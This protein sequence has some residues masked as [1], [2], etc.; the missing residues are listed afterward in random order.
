MK[1]ANR[2]SSRCDSL[3]G[4][5]G[6][7][8]LLAESGPGRCHATRGEPAG[9]LGSTHETAALPEIARLAHARLHATRI[10]MRGIRHSFTGV[11]WIN[12]GSSPAQNQLASEQAEFYNELSQNYS[13]VFPEQQAVLSA[14]TSEFAPI[15]AAGPNQTGFSPQEETSLRTTASDTT[16][17]AA[18]Q[19]DVALGGKEATMGDASIP[20]GAKLQLESGLLSSAAGENAALQNQITQENYAAGLQNFDTAANALSGVAGLENPNAFASAATTSGAAAN[21]TFQD[22]AQENSAWLGPVF[23]AIGGLGG[24]VINQNPG[25]VFG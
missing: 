12:C 14:L 5:A 24:A 7:P 25:N 15:L 9:V 23:G 11:K 4:W 16:A 10:A 3:I 20:S 8:Q 13:T 21:N 6:S 17:N 22:I 1:N 19:A 2:K 18:Q